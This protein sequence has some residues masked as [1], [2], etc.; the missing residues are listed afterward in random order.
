MVVRTE[1][2]EDYSWPQLERLLTAGKIVDHNGSNWWLALVFED[3]TILEIANPNARGNRALDVALKL[4]RGSVADSKE[5]QGETLDLDA[6]KMA[7]C[8]T[9]EDLVQSVN[10][11][12]FYAT[13]RFLKNRL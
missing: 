10:W 1:H 11:Q 7:F 12:K 3:G 6:F 9:M 2:D 13:Y 4:G 8:K 5:A